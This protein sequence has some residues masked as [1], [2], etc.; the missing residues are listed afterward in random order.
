MPLS[1]A[2]NSW[3]DHVRD[4]ATKNNI[5][6]AC[7]LSSPQCSAQYVKPPKAVRA[8]KLTKK[9]KQENIKMTMEDIPAPSRKEG[10]ADIFESATP[11]EGFN[12]PAVRALLKDKGKEVVKRRITDQEGM[13]AEDINRALPKKTGKPGRPS[14]YAN[15]EEARKAKIDN[16]IRRAKERV[17]EKKD[18]RLQARIDRARR[19]YNKFLEMMEGNVHGDG[20]G[21][22]TENETI[23]QRVEKMK[24]V[25]PS[26]KV[27]DWY[28][29]LV[30]KA[31]RSGKVEPQ[32]VQLP[33]ELSSLSGRGFNVEMPRTGG[34]FGWVKSVLGRHPQ[35]TR[36]Q[37]EEA[38]RFANSL[39]ADPRGISFEGA[40]VIPIDVRKE[41][42]EEAYNRI[43]MGKQDKDAPPN[44]AEAFA[45]EIRKQYE[46]QKKKGKGRM[47]GGFSF[48]DFVSG[49]NKANPVMWGIQNKPEVG[50]QL[51]KT[52]NDTLLPAVVAV[53]KPVYDALAVEAGTAITGNPAMGKVV[54][55]EFWN[56]YGRPYD[57]RDRQDNEAIKQISDKVGKEA[58]R[59]L[60]DRVRGRG[61]KK[62]GSTPP[63]SSS[64]SKD[65][66]SPAGKKRRTGSTTQQQ[67]PFQAQPLSLTPIPQHI[68]NLFRPIGPR[69]PPSQTDLPLSRPKPRRRGG[70]STEQKGLSAEMRTYLRPPLT[71]ALNEIIHSNDAPYSKYGVTPNRFRDFT[72]Q[73]DPKAQKEIDKAIG[74]LVKM[75]VLP[76]PVD[77]SQPAPA[78]NA[79][80]PVFQPTGSGSSNLNALWESER[81]LNGG[82]GGDPSTYTPAYLRT[83]RLGADPRTY[84]PLHLPQGGAIQG[85]RVLGD[86]SNMI[87]HLISHITNPNEPVDPRDYNQT[88]GII[89]SIRALKGGRFL[90]GR[91]IPPHWD[92]PDIHES[93]PS[94]PE[95]VTVPTNMPIFD[96]E[97]TPPPTPEE[98]ELL[99]S[100]TIDWHA[101]GQALM[102]PNQEGVEYVTPEN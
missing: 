79:N 94:S 102:D 78:L 76:P 66:C 3:T 29:P 36:E 52:T 55:D 91:K 57:P 59:K 28:R 26:L 17:G 12:N 65:T 72:N 32:T 53:G 2:G 82:L 56:Q 22:R 85:R 74:V 9:E 20:K 68:D 23:I 96:D 39:M 33:A 93:Q 84:T 100:P 41:L 24:K 54:G 40:S 15:A 87:R 63:N 45:D 21:K 64:S 49:L 99:N 30:Y 42:A 34:M 8:K 50:I 60:F 38:E 101:I 11:I 46:A 81:R 6:Y 4:F 69:A 10:L 75:G 89:N 18:A 47:C 61:R 98:D 71:F 44:P 83:P 25:Y 58:S 97:P 31:D 90:G 1:G 92:I 7:A 48:N 16:T 27:S 51:G 62:G 86:Y 14:K 73:F 5:S 35:L 13:R 88:I 70:A 77:Y 43:L 95:L 67:Q 37:Q 80:A 19:D